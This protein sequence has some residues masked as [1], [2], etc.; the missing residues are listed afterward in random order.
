MTLR[1]M[2]IFVAVCKYNSITT[3]AKSLFLAQPA[4]SLAI[5]ELEAFYGIRL[6]ERIAKRLYITDRGKQFLE[7]AAHIVSLFEEMETRMKDQDNIGTL[8][9]GS[10]ITVGNH[11]LPGFVEAFRAKY[12][13]IRLQVKIQN[14]EDIEKQIVSNELDLAFIEGAIHHPQIVYEKFS[15]DR[16]ALI[17]GQKHQLYGRKLIQPSELSGYDFILREKGSGG[18]ELFDSMLLVHDIRIEPIWESVSTQAVIRAVMSG[19]GLSALPYLMVK[20]YLDRG[21]ISEIEI[22]GISLQRGFYVIYHC[23][24]FLTNSARDLIAICKGEP[25]SGDSCQEGRKQE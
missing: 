1:H 8:R 2:K 22:K 4:V 5:G 17:C 18:R 21:E 23:K 16:L 3:A 14:S 19:F 25:T 24:K 13:G 9:V 15:E 20:P 7:Y 12:P 6:F 11:L 10:S